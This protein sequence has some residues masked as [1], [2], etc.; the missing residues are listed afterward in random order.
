LADLF[1]KVSN[2]GLEQNSGYN[3][4]YRLI[5]ATFNGGPVRTLRLGIDICYILAGNL[6]SGLKLQYV[7]LGQNSLGRFLTQR[8]TVSAQ[9]K[10]S[11]R[12]WLYTC[13][14]TFVTLKNDIV[15][16]DHWF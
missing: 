11:C 16:S 7:E 13:S 5:S 8:R 9:V 12:Y 1:G 6:L 2:Q 14:Y 10:T 3:D 4:L 15:L